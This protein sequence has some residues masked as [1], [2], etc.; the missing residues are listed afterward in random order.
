MRNL[1]IAVSLFIFVFGCSPAANN[2]PSKGKSIQALVP[3]PADP[4]TIDSQLKRFRGQ[5]EF[6]TVSYHSR[7][8]AGQPSKDK[9]GGAESTAERAMQESD[10]FKIG[11]PGTKLLFLL[12]NISG[13]LRPKSRRAVCSCMM[14]LNRRLQLSY[15]L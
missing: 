7:Y 8:L 2:G 6:L 15:K 1:L 10:I 9:A 11:K 13:I 5:T 4:T 14:F 3:V 12:N